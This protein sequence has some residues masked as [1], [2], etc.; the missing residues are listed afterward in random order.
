MVFGY[1]RN[2][3]RPRGILW[4][5]GPLRGRYWMHGRV[6]LVMSYLISVLL[7]SYLVDRHCNLPIVQ[8]KQ[9]RGAIIRLRPV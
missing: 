8:R 9:S 3:A 1:V 5:I 2:R 7:S 4:G 6:V